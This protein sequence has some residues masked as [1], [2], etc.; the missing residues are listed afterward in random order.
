[1]CSVIEIEEGE[2]LR[3]REDILRKNLS[4]RNCWKDHQA[5]A[6]THDILMLVRH[7]L[8][9]L[10]RHNILQRLR[11][12]ILQSP[13]CSRSAGRIT[14]MT[15]TIDYAKNNTPIVKNVACCFWGDASTN[16]S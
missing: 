8:A 1:M 16:M 9:L 11:N 13:L 6:R 7:D 5:I 14:R 10:L 4:T 15:L 3:W 12:Y 2:L